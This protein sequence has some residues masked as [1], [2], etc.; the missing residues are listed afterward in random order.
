MSNSFKCFIVA[1]ALLS[2]YGISLAETMQQPPAG[3]GP[4]AMKK[5]RSELS[6]PEKRLALMKQ[7]LSLTDDQVARIRPIIVAEQAELEKLRGDSTLNR[8]Q[9]RVKLQELNK[10]TSDNVRELLT[11]EQ[12]TKQDSIKAK[13]AENRSKTRGARPGAVPVE[14]TPEKRIVRLTEHLAL[15]LEQQDKIMPILQDEYTQLKTLPGN[16][17]YNRDQRRAKLQQLTQETNSKIMPI[18]T[19][20]QQKKYKETREKII[21][22]R[23]QKKRGGEKG[24]EREPK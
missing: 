7:T 18:L 15:T 19:P 14:F 8:D 13:I 12:Q 5:Q 16:D 17:T 9:R 23:S 4:A 21:D 22:R 3:R 6:N 2:F 24:L 11:P 20:E 1:S 10:G